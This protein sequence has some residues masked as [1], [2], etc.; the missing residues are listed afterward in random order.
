MFYFSLS[1]LTMPSWNLTISSHYRSV[2]NIKQQLSSISLRN[3][4]CPSSLYKQS[5]CWKPRTTSKIKTSD[6]V[7]SRHTYYAFWIPGFG[8]GTQNKRLA[9]HQLDVFDN[10]VDA[11]QLLIL[12]LTGE[13]H[14][15]TAERSLILVN[16]NL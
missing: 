13:A 7:W 6:K 8:D 12:Y 1:I 10:L 16:M 2:C 5:N 9:I 4:V 15:C 14:I 11:A 3:P